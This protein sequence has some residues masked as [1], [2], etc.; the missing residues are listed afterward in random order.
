MN[1]AALQALQELLNPSSTE[2]G[3]HEV[4]SADFHVK[5]QCVGCRSWTQRPPRT[6]HREA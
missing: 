4:N 2:Q 6:P 5:S 1:G 3:N